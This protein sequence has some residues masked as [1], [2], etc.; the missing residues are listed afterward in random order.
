[1]RFRGDVLLT[2]SLALAASAARGAA[3]AQ[4]PLPEH[5]RPD[6]ERAEWVNLNGDR[7]LRFDADGPASASAGSRRR[8]SG[9]RSGSGCRSP[10]ARSCRASRTRPTSRGTRGRVRVPEAWRGQR[11]FLVVGA[12]DWETSGWLDGTAIGSHRGATRPSSSS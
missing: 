10:G 9:S 12:S 11:V 2:C 5:P 7:G 4:I 8:S 6:L 3:A 1:M